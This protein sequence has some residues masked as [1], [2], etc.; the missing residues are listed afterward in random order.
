MA[1]SDAKGQACIFLNKKQSHM[2][3]SSA[4]GTPCCLISAIAA[5]DKRHSP[6]EIRLYYLKYQKADEL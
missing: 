3:I 1:A 6:W 2:S 5:R 4:S